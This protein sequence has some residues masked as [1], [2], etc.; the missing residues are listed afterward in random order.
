LINGRIGPI[1]I[2]SQKLL[3]VFCRMGI[4][5]DCLIPK[6]ELEKEIKYPVPIRQSIMMI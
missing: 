5:P 6:L 3:E 4:L 1:A 2:V